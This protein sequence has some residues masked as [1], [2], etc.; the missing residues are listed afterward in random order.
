MLS[1]L[2]LRLHIECVANILR[3]WGEVT[4]LVSLW[5]KTHFISVL[6]SLFLRFIRF[7]CEDSV[8]GLV[9]DVRG[10]MTGWDIIRVLDFTFEYGVI[11]FCFI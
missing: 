11:Y 8:C 1:L 5:D 7:D 4:C 6:T 9:L 3:V 10:G 2:G